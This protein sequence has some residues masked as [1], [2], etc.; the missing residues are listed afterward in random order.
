LG[1]VEINL[2]T[3]IV[4]SFVEVNAMGELFDERLPVSQYWIAAASS[5]FAPPDTWRSWAD[6]LIL[7]LDDVPTWLMNLSLAND[8]TGLLAA[9][10][11][12]RDE[13]ALAQGDFIPIV[14]AKL[15]YLYLRYE[16]AD[17]SLCEFLEVAGSEADGGTGDLHCEEIYTLLNDIEEA[18][19]R[20]Q[21]VA[22][23][24]AQVRL[25]FAPYATTAV[26]QWATI[27][28]ILAD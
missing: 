25:I 13:E 2:L 9:L 11:S 16:R 19:R 18:I 26:Q 17:Y 27:E 6:A 14:N 15:G 8:V 22:Q 20:Q 5:G 1:H 3:S 21:S 28:S 12:K 4:G 10:S 23:F 7:R 24:E